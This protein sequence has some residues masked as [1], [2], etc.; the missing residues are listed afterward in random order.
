MTSADVTEAETSDG[1][2]K[3]E[4]KQ[5]RRISRLPLPWS[6]NPDLPGES[7]ELKVSNLFSFGTAPVGD[8]W[9]STKKLQKKKRPK[10]TEGIVNA[11]DL[12][13]G[14]GR[15]GIVST[16][17]SEL[18]QSERGLGTLS[19]QPWL[20]QSNISQSSL[21]ASE[22][23]RRSHI[24]SNRSSVEN[25]RAATPLD[26]RPISLTPTTF[27]ELRQ[28][29]LQNQDNDDDLPTR[30]IM[31]AA[32]EDRPRAGSQS[33]NTSAGSSSKGSKIG[34]WLRKKRGLSV[35]SSTSAGG[36]GGAVV[37]D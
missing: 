15:P 34:A 12:A 26:R 37:S 31:P 2:S 28:R 14:I 7:K 17:A 6:S 18:S 23:S 4:K 21:N 9:K 13:V 25:P 20:H 8:Q 10:E 16:P 1:A 11:I 33:S 22:L 3:S 32:R 36:G 35:S 29:N 24:S 5:K 30:V 19:P 27:E